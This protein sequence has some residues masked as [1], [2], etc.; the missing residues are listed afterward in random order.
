LLD[1][2]RLGQPEKAEERLAVLDKECFFG[3]EE[4][5]ELKQ[6]IEEYRKLN[7]S[8]VDIGLPATRRWYFVIS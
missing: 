3:C 6:A 1:W 8:R 5:D 2:L 7:P 4:Y